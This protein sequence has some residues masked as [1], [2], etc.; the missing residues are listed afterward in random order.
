M[1]REIFPGKQ[2]AA[3]E[4]LDPSGVVQHPLVLLV[5]GNLLLEQFCLLLEGEDLLRH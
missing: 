5:G 3:L 1:H 4:A 2:L